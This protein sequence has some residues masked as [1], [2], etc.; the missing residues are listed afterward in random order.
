MFRKTAILTGILFLI[1]TGSTLLSFPFAGVLL[2][3]SRFLETL[4][5][6]STSIIM[7]TLLEFIWA[8]SC[9]GIAIALYTVLRKYD[10]FL[11]FGAVALRVIEAMFVLTGTLCLLSL[12]TVSRDF[13]VAGP[14]DAIA[15]QTSASVLSNVRY[16]SHNYIASLAFTSGALL[17]YIVLFRSR[18]IPRWL[19]VW[20]GIGVLLSLAATMLS[21]NTGDFG[22]SSI[23]TIL[24][25]PIGLNELVLAIWLI[26]KGFNPG[27]AISVKS[28]DTGQEQP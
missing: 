20:G 28:H 5:G 17:Y 9:A 8:V 2:E 7:G 1:C 21:A 16:W 25:I 26:V 6:K 14:E 18:L 15:L 4:A 19:S 3:D 24:N 13:I 10:R 23:N 11:A 27:T 12:L 22:F